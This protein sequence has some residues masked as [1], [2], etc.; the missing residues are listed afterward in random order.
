MDTQEHSLITIVWPTFYVNMTS[1]LSERGILTL[2]ENEFMERSRKT[3]E[4]VGARNTII[5]AVEF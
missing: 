1:Q 3:D 5:C 4:Q 2:H